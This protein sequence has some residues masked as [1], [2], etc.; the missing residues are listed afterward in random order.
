MRLPLETLLEAESRTLTQSVLPDLST[1]Y[2][3][4]QL[5]AVVDVI[6][7]LRDRIEMRTDL[8]AEEASSA[9]DALARAALR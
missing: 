1:R 3:R 9:A 8:L 7:N 6:R 5:F 4:G 2:A